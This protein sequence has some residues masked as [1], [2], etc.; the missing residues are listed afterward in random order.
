MKLNQNILEEKAKNID[1][2][3]TQY[4]MQ[5]LTDGMSE[6]YS[7]IP[8]DV[9]KVSLFLDADDVIMNTSVCLIN[10]YNREFESNP[11]HRWADIN[12]LWDWGYK[13]VCPLATPEWIDNFFASMEDVMS[14]KEMPYSKNAIKRLSKL[15]NIKVVTIGVPENIVAKTKWFASKFPDIESIAYLC[16]KG[17][18][19]D[20]SIINMD[21]GIFVD[22]N[23]NNLKSSNANIKIAFGEMR[24]Y[25]R[26][27]TLR[28]NDFNELEGYLVNVAK[29]IYA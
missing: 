24:E 17:C 29:E 13:S 15:Y 26:K 25:N 7:S 23:Y 22:D 8:K 19:M 27:A 18:K 16:N 6:I 12:D 5:R 1:S 20:K 9:K 10:K 11:L 4:K 2:T 3:V 21:N 14:I 28:V